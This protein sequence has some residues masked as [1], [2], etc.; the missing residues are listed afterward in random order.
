MRAPGQTER[1]L[2]LGA[3]GFGKTTLAQRVYQARVQPG[4][5]R[6]VVIDRKGEL[7]HLGRVVGT[8]EEVRATL[9]AAK[10]GP[11]S[12]VLV[13]EWG[14]DI[15]G[16]WRVLCEAGRL[17]LLVDEMQVWAGHRGAD[18]DFLELIRLARG[19]GV[20]FMGTTHRPTDIQ[21]IFRSLYTRVVTFAQ[22]TP[23]DAEHMAR[24]YLDAPQLARVL[25]QLPRFHYLTRPFGGAVTRGGPNA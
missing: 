4:R 23:E 15:S 19:Y 20:D 10:G 12:L 6:G 3:S 25:Q 11:V 16:V 9:A 18:A 13:P 22:P 7:R 24:G 14:A 1:W 17:L 21:P 5:G 8:V 2:L